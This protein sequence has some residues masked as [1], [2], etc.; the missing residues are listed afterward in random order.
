MKFNSK[1]GAYRAANVYFHPEKLVATSYDWWTFVK[2]IDGHT[3]FNSYGYSNTTRR[4]QYRV[5]EVMRDL[6]LV[7]DREVRVPSSLS[8]FDNMMEIIAA[9]DKAE[10]KRLADERKKRDLKNARA[11]ERRAE[12][13]GMGKVGF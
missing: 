8:N 1:V 10:A 11:R 12:A 4:H 9:H 7:I 2:R 5:R 6:G 3:V 13:R